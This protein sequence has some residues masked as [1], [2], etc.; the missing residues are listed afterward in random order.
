MHVYSEQTEYTH[1]YTKKGTMKE[2]EDGSTWL[3]LR[4]YNGE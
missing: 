1:G 4:I 3:A 2:L